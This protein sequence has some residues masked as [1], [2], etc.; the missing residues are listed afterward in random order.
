M[1]V[2]LTW[3]RL[4][5]FLTLMFHFLILVAVVNNCMQIGFGV[6]IW[7]SFCILGG[8]SIQWHCH[9]DH[10]HFDSK[11][12]GLLRSMYTSMNP[13]VCWYE[14]LCVSGGTYLSQLPNE[15]CALMVDNCVHNLWHLAMVMS[16][17][18][19]GRLKM[20]LEFLGCWQLWLWAC[21]LLYTDILLE[22]LH[23]E[24]YSHFTWALE[25]SCSLNHWLRC[26]ILEQ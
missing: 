21:K 14:A 10:T 8:I 17:G 5:F 18:V 16:L 7:N 4:V 6:G 3:E 20:K 15:I 25:F 11:L 23:I 2:H 24:M 22:S 19:V 1:F 13:F 26:L 9:W 12:P